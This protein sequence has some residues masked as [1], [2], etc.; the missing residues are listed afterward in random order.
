M[1]P[2][3]RSR[4]IPLFATLV[5]SA[6][7]GVLIAWPQAFGAQLTPIIA[8]LLA[9]RGLVAIALLV[10]AGGAAVVAVLRRRWSI[11]AGIAI[12]L[13]ATS[14][15]SGAILASRSAGET[16]PNG[17]L[18][19]V[20][21]NTLG[22]AVSP[23]SIAELIVATDADIVT[24]P[25]T[26]AVAVAETARIV[27][28]SGREMWADTAYG[29]TGDSWIPTSVLIATDLGQYRVDEAA[30]STPGLPSGVWRPLN[31]IGPTIVAAHPLPPSLEDMAGWRAGLE[32]VATQCGEPDVIVAG[33]LNA[34]IDHL[35]ALGRGESLIG[36]CRDAAS[37]SGAAAAGSWPT[38]L[39]VW[40]ASPIDHVLVGSAWAVHEVAVDSSFDDRGSDHRP[41]IAHL[42]RN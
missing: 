27:S 39:P 34:T 16:V 31:G 41:I 15:T 42:G 8:Q 2:T 35:S 21:W 37:E 32:W 33:D 4:G 1:M 13:G 38:S 11:A 19:V 10:L 5:V 28:L 9:F 17:D 26:D 30:G 18:V 20:S 3:R 22:G 14:L 6:P 7:V 40:L 25:E 12:I 23:E 24:L 36:D 29:E